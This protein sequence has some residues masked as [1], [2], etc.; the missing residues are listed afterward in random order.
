MEIVE[1]EAGS[2]GS[3]G[4]PVVGNWM[5]VVVSGSVGVQ[6]V[7]WVV[8]RRENGRVKTGVVWLH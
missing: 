1:K 2:V 5:R 3:L 8:G 6:K 7:I 4:E